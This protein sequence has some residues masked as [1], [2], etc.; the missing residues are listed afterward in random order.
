[1]E[2]TKVVQKIKLKVKQFPCLGLENPSFENLIQTDASEIG[3]GGILKQ[4]NLSTK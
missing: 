3:Y 2:H 1:M 4:K